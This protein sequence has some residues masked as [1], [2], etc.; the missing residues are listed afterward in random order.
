[1][2]AAASDPVES[3]QYAV[4]FV[5]T[6]IVWGAGNV[7]QSVLDSE[8][9]SITAFEQGK[10]VA[11][12]SRA[13]RLATRGLPAIQKIFA[14]AAVPVKSGGGN[15]QEHADLTFMWLYENT[16]GLTLNYACGDDHAYVIIGDPNQ[17]NSWL[18]VD[19]WPNAARIG[20]YK[21]ACQKVRTWEIKGVSDRNELQAAQQVYAQSLASLLPP[22]TPA[23]D[24]PALGHYKQAA[25]RAYD[26][27]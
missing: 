14:R 11:D 16:T 10:S 20:P 25:E 7:K 4:R 2:Q 26:V 18:V 21:V 3:A 6:I 27:G 19:P 17:E 9:R 8:G 1:M 5:K 12:R 24:L 15:C 13:Y 22:E 23:E